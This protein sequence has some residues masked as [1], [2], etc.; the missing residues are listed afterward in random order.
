MIQEYRDKLNITEGK[1]FDFLV[2][3]IRAGEG[4]YIYT[5]RGLKEDLHVHH[6]TIHKIIE[7][8]QAEGVFVIDDL[9]YRKGYRIQFKEKELW[10]QIVP[11]GHTE[12]TKETINE[13]REEKIAEETNGENGNGENDLKNKKEVVL[14]GRSKELNRLLEE[15]KKRRD[16]LFYGPIGS[17]KTT[18]LLSAYRKL[19]EEG[20]CKVVYADYSGSFKIFLIHLAFQIHEKY[21]DLR[22]YEMEDKKQDIA[23]L[24]WRNIRIKI[25]RM[26][27]NDLAGVVL[28]SVRGKDY[29]VMC[30]QLE[31]V[32]PTAK[33]I[34]EAL[35]EESCLVGAA[36]SI[37]RSGHFKKL[38][39]RFKRIEITNLR[40]KEAKE[41]VDYLYKE[42]GVYAY[43]PQMYKSKVLKMSDGNPAAIVDMV[44][45]GS[46]EKYIDKQHIREMSH[47]AGERE[48]DL[49]PFVL[50]VGVGVV[51]LRFFALGMNDTDIYIMAGTGGAFFMFIRFFLYRTMKREHSY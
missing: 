32:S 7:K 21:K 9:G 38:W 51:A 49:T 45:H 50:L 27:V 25:K 18:I 28:K 1:I 19:D 24:T 2:E 20:N 5:V 12:E 33:S 22:L 29:I 34:F 8:F 44:Y 14:I 16:T 43:Y 30:D 23:Q 11:I 47:E 15:I 40:D 13:A 41:L 4:G 10:K 6:Q 3:Q 42:K 37:N 31:K 36:W 39:W 48:F 46:L 17:G 26:T 35:R